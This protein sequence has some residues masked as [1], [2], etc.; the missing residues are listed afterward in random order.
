MRILKEDEN[1]LVFTVYPTKYFLLFVIFLI[2]IFVYALF[3]PEIS[4][5]NSITG[6]L[7]V[8]LSTSESILVG[9]ILNIAIITYCL[10]VC[11][12]SYL[13][14]IHVVIDKTAK[15]ITY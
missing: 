1:H 9:A 8:K 14:P 6:F 11:I 7:N 4:T 15:T 12:A 3:H 13:I 5:I 10:L 2:L